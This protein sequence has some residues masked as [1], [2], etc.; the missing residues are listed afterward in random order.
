MAH[1]LKTPRRVTTRSATKTMPAITFKALTPKLKMAKPKSNAVKSKTKAPSTPDAASKIPF[2]KEDYENIHFWLESKENFEAVSGTSGKTPIGKEMKLPRQ[3]WTELAEIVSRKSKG[4][5]SIGPRAMKE[6]FKRYKSKYY[7]TKTV[8]L[9]TGFGIVI[10]DRRRG[11]YSITDKLDNMCPFFNKMDK[12]FG[13][14]SNVVPLGEICMNNMTYL[15]GVDGFDDTSIEGS[16]FDDEASGNESSKAAHGTQDGGTDTVKRLVP[17]VLLNDDHDLDEPDHQD[18]GDSDF[19]GCYE[20]AQP[21]QA[22]YTYNSNLGAEEREEA[23]DHYDVEEAGKLSVERENVQQ[24]LKDTRK[25]PP[26]LSTGP[27]QQSRNGFASA[28]AESAAA[29]LRMLK[30]QNDQKLALEKEARLI[31]IEVKNRK[32]E[33]E[34]KKL[35]TEKELLS[36]RLKSEAEAESRKNR[37]I[38]VQSALAQG[39]DANAIKDLLDLVDQCPW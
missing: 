35:A 15:H 21:D 30:E 17:Q 34:E 7:K 24:K 31:Q 11:I 26:K 9:G 10:E 4:R 3:G 39:L 36:M 33:L 2:L 20:Q 16:D 23:S 6:R 12:L 27:I 22:E 37:S 28:Y 14:K 1:T 38:I 5:I 8:S 25:A 18:Q 13:G 19:E 32:I 29:K